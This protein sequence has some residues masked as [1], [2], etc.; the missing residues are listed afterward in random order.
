VELESN[1][2]DQ[3]HVVFRPRIDKKKTFNFE[4]CLMFDDTSPPVQ[5]HSTNKVCHSLSPIPIEHIANVIKHKI[6]L[7]TQTQPQPQPQT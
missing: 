3:E 5:I 2:S 4:V 6:K 1:L 7:Q